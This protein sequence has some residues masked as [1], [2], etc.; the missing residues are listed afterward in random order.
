MN[1][2]VISFLRRSV[3]LLGLTVFA[4][5]LF[6]A[7]T[8]K[9][10]PAMW[11]IRDK[12]STIYLIG[13]VH[14]LRHEMEWDKTKVAKTVTES[15]EL[16]LEVANIT[17]TAAISPII[18]QYG[19]DL[20]HPLST[21]LTAAQK[22]KLSQ[23][24]ATYGVPMESLEMIKPWMAAM[25]FTLLPLQKAGFDQS[26][27]VDLFLKTQAEKE[28]DKICGFET[29]EQQVRIFAE[30][31][32]SEQIS[33]LEETLRDAEKGTAQLEQ[34]A[35]AWLIGDTETIGNI[36][37]NDLKKES[38][39]LYQKFVVQRNIAWSQKIAE[40]LKRSGVQQIAVGAAHLTGPDSLQVQLAR[41]G[42][43]VERY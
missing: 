14:L 41:R 5:P 20:E 4:A 27:G 17:D 26:A 42:I 28:G 43:K 21:K 8:A 39:S 11:V 40:I 29:A 13:T 7:L 22:E 36:L 18:A 19:M 12:D 3:R 15:S 35:R 30:L 6:F 37:V 31:P 1:H 34:L 24:A 16:W 33:F 38:P 9:A 23:V 10:E 2:L 25:M 32:D